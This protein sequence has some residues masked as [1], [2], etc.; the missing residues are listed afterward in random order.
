MLGKAC[1]ELMSE[2]YRSKIGAREKA[3]SP[4]YLPLTLYNYI[5]YIYNCSIKEIRTKSIS[6]DFELT[7]HKTFP[8]KFPTKCD[9]FHTMS[10][11]PSSVTK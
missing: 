8:T 1:Q 4:T 11:S 3:N 2:R 10:V 9:C 7:E 6:F 5:Y